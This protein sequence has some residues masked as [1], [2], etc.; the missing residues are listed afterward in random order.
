MEKHNWWISKCNGLEYRGELFEKKSSYFSKAN[1]LSKQLWSN[2]IFSGMHPGG[3]ILNFDN[4]RK[5]QNRGIE[6][7]DALIHIVDAPKIDE[8][9]DNEVFEFI[10]KYNA[11]WGIALPDEAKYPGMCN[12][13][14]KVWT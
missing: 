10:D 6:H 12:L 2:I 7:I 9:E 13:A 11:W 14:K 1:Y 5:F 8:N 3:Q 4:W